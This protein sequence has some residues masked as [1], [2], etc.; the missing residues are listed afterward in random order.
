MDHQLNDFLPDA[1]AP[2]DEKEFSLVTL[3]AIRA[4]LK[5]RKIFSYKG[6]YGHALIVAGARETMGAALL[7][8]K[9]CLQAGAGLTTACIP[10]SGLIALNTALPEVM[11]LGRDALGFG[12]DFLKKYNVVGIGPG[13]NPDPDDTSVN[14]EMLDKILRS[15]LSIVA[16]ADALT[17]L[18][19][20]NL[21]DFF[22]R[23]VVFT[24]H[25]KEFDRLFGKH[26]TWWGRL[27]T[28]KAKAAEKGIIIVLKNQFTFVVDQKGWVHV[29]T[30]GNPAIAQ[31]G[32]GDVLTGIITAFIAQGYTGIE[33]A[34]LG[35]YIHGMAGDTLSAIYA[36][37]TASALASQV[38][39][40][41][42]SLLSEN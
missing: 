6:T 22:D 24:P 2:D 28:A 39:K 30:T 27:E 18:S 12:N 7:A 37:I 11:Y 19:V 5:P 42:K 4:I 8:A 21:P 16:D 32:M 35:C 34:L 33:A 10:E 9:G 1:S 13:F 20:N 25:V 26:D 31:G 3:T 40:T 29:N 36:N 17:M 14:G 23:Q 38:P 15:S 41:I